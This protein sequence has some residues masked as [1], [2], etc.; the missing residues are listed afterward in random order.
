MVTIRKAMSTQSLH[1]RTATPVRHTGRLARRGVRFTVSLALVLLLVAR[2][3]LVPCARADS[4][5]GDANGDGKVTEADAKLILRKTVSSAI[6][7]T[8]EFESADMNKDGKVDPRDAILAM[9]ATAADSGFSWDG[10]QGRARVENGAVEVDLVFEGSA[11]RISDTLKT[12]VLDLGGNLRG[13]QSPMLTGTAARKSTSLLFPIAGVSEAADLATFVLEIEGHDG[14]D[15]VRERFSL[16]ELTSRLRVHVFGPERW[17]AGAINRARVTVQETSTGKPLPG[18]AVTALLTGPDGEEACASFSGAADANGVVNAVLEIPPGLA[19]EGKLL[20]AVHSPGGG[21]LVNQG[22]DI[23]DG[24]TT[25][26]TTDKP[27]YQPGQTIHMRSLSLKKPQMLP[28]AGEEMVLTVSDAKG[29]KVFK[30]AGTLNEFGVASADFVLATELNMGEYTIA[31]EIAGSRTEKQVTVE[32]YALPKFKVTLATDRDFYR[33]GAKVNGTVGADYFF[34]KSVSGADVTVT[35]SKFDVGFNEFAK[36]SGTTDPQGRFDFSLDLPAYFVGQPLQQGDAFAL[37]QVEVV[38]TA[39]HMQSI[40]RS[41]PVSA[42]EIVIHAVPESGCLIPGVE[43]LVYVLTLYPNNTPARTTC[44]AHVGGEEIGIVSTDAAGIGVLLFTPAGHSALTLELHAQDS[45]G[46]AASRSFDLALVPGGETILA[47]TDRALYKVGDEIK[48]DVFCGG[49]GGSVFVDVVKEG[50]TV[51]SRSL[52]PDGGHTAL[53]LPLGADM[54]GTLSISA[55][56]ITLAGNTIRDRRIIYVDPA[57]DLKLAYAP[58]KD[59][60]LPGEDAS[61]QLRVSDPAGKPVVAAVG[62]NIV[63]E[64]VFALQEMQPGMEKVYFYLEEQLR[65]PRYEIHGFSPEEIVHGSSLDDSDAARERAVGMMFATLSTAAPGTFELMSE[66]DDPEA[67]L[68]SLRDAVWADVGKLIDAIPSEFGWRDT[69]RSIAF[70]EPAISQALQEGR[71]KPDDAVDPWGTFYHV[72][73][74]ATSGEYTFL[75]AGP[76][77]RWDTADDLRLATVYW[78]VTSP[79]LRE[80]PDWQIRANG[81]INA[82][83]FNDATGWIEAG[84]GGGVGPPSV[85]FSGQS[86]SGQPYLRQYFPETLYSN[87]LI[88]TGPDGSATVDVKV[89]DSITSWR[90]TGLAS[91]ADGRLGSATE[92]IRVFQEFFVDLDLPAALTR[93]DEVSVPVAVYNYLP[94][95]QSIRLEMQNSEGFELLDSADKTLSIGADEVS[96]VYFRVK[97]LRVGRFK[98]QVTAYG[99]TRSDAI[100]REVEVTPDGSEVLVTHSGRLSGTVERVISIPAEAIKDASKILVKIYPGFFSQVVEGLDSMLRMPFGCFEQTSS[101]TYPNVLVVEYMKRVDQIT[102]ETLMKAEGFISAGYQRLLSYEVDGGGFSWFGDKPAHKVLTTYGLME[103]SDMSKVWYVDPAVIRRTQEW[104]V[105]E[106]EPDGS[107]IPTDGGIAEGAIDR[108]QNDVLRTTA[109]VVWG[110]GSSGYSGPAPGSG[111]AYM[112]TKL[113][114]PEF[115]PE[116]YTLALCA[117]AL[118]KDPS[119]PL[120]P[121]LFNQFEASKHEEGDLVWWEETAP[122]ITGSRGQGASVELTALLA[123]AYLRFGAYPNTT[124]KAL[125]FLVSSKDGNGNFGS[126]QATVQALKAFCL[127]ASGVTSSADATVRIVMDGTEVKTLRLTE[128]NNDLLLLCDLGEHTKTGENV[129]R[130]TFEGTGSSLY[131][132]IGR[133]YMPWNTVEPPAEELLSIDVQFDKEQLTTD[134]LVTCTVR[135]ANNRPGKAKM[136]V[137]DVGVP[138]GFEALRDDLDALVGKGIQKYELAGRQII[139]YLEELDHEKPV[140]LTYKLAAKYP[141]R[142]KTTVSTVYEY[143]N[144]EVRSAAEPRE[145]IVTN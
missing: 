39:E 129:V 16:Y 80:N 139:F 115:K 88:I 33:P 38:D 132:V 133:H 13:I 130:L 67:L 144:P 136:I 90:L 110:L 46:N 122:T 23:V 32:R 121:N 61:I 100:A 53:V 138:P 17:Y 62:L 120:L 50:Q 22:V 78:A 54:S 116:T 36:I 11:A 102:P 29:N 113:A 18:T 79:W 49:L 119:D 89:A 75:C 27:L 91:S 1:C 24:T 4:T 70:F 47:R 25:L 134:D 143:Y 71:L 69:D 124:A 101:V 5:P 44:T 81:G 104:L 42:S 57:N 55:Y 43:N 117:H 2:E 93:M 135:V 76:D 85:D 131:Q 112:K 35:A 97:A 125:N 84:V 21:R 30:Q 48:L 99:S 60:Y 10:F 34:G 140:T 12:R 123:Q 26:L 96:V 114:E 94:V 118:L 52:E 87:P 109:Y 95:A 128:A 56:R 74:T 6:L 82:L 127:A 15:T 66:T 51:Y 108:F 83:F 58:D 137:V 20:V 40:S 145:I 107:W 3:S 37:I 68:E 103:F 7:G 19:G 73:Y 86:G 126:T 92:S 77:K 8:A 31:A 64:A 105:S 9:R 63:D 14:T 65:Q 106:Q 142:A 98:L 28:A 72:S 45:Q 111:I 59:V 41:I 141:I